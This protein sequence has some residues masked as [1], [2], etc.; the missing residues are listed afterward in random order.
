MWLADI[1]WDEP[2]GHLITEKLFVSH[3][4]RAIIIVLSSLT[5]LI[6]KSL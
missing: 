5:T 6:S 1:G 2:D 4:H 3:P